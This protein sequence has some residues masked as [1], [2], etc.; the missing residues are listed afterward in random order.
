MRPRTEKT[1]PAQKSQRGKKR[2]RAQVIIDEERED[3]H[4][5]KFKQP[6]LI[7]GAKMKDY[8]LEGLA[9]MVGLYENGISG[10]LGMFSCNA[11]IKYRVLTRYVLSR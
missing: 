7:T 2:T 1:K 6:S 3:I 5:Q 10:I 8:Q 11:F 9:W 4:E